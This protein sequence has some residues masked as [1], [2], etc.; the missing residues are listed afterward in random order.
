LQHAGEH[1]WKDMKAGLELAWD[2]VEAAF[3]SARSRFK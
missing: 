2:A 3:S 1:A